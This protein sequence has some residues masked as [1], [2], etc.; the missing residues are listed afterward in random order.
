MAR[1]YFDN[2]DISV[3]VTLDTVA[4]CQDDDVIEVAESDMRAM[5]LAY[6]FPVGRKGLTGLIRRAV[7]R[8]L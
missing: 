2:N 4:I 3:T 5:C 7:V 6:L 8:W 1:T